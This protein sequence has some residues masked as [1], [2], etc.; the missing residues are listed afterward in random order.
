MTIIVDG[1]GGICQSLLV[2]TESDR[3]TNQTNQT[4]Q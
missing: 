2:A 3:T 1:I 4:N